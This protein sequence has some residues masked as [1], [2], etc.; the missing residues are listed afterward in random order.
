MDVLVWAARAHA[1]TACAHCSGGGRFRKIGVFTKPLS[2]A[3]AH[4]K[5]YVAEDGQIQVFSLPREGSDAAQRYDTAQH[6]RY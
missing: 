4:G 3:V 5:I 2:V 1:G 6:Y